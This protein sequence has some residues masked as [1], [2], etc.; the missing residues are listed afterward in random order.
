ME[1]PSSLAT[2]VV[3]DLFSQQMQ[4]SV[5]DVDTS[6]STAV[7]VRRASNQLSA[8]PFVVSGTFMSSGLNLEHVADSVDRE[9]SRRLCLVVTYA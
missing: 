1:N 2:P 5:W 4:Q 3:T 8:V 6:G 9:C 7:T